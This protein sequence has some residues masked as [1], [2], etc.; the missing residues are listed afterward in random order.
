[1]ELLQGVRFRLRA[2]VT[3]TPR[4]SHLSPAHTELK[5]A[6]S[7]CSAVCKIAV[8]CKNV[9]QRLLMESMWNGRLKVLNFLIQVIII[10]NFSVDIHSLNTCC[11]KCVL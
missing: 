2:H 4:V 3:R 11:I 7:K 9:G 8:T 5:E 10:L 1:V 6:E